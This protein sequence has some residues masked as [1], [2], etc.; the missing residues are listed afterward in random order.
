[1]TAGQLL[2]A[3]WAC[4]SAFFALLW[5]A[6]VRSRD[7]SLVDVGWALGLGFVGASAALVLDG[8]PARRALVG[9]MA[10]GWSLRLAAHLYF[11][12]VRGKPEDGRYAALRAS[13]GAGA[14]GKFFVFFQAQALLDVLLGLSFVAVA[15]RPGP[16]GALDAAGALLWLASVSGEAL[17]DRRLA[18]FRADPANKGQVCR[19]GLWSLSRH[20]NYF[21]EWTHWLAYGAM[22]PGDW[23]V[24]VAPPLMLYFL[25]RVTGIPA[26]E[27]QAL[28]GR[29]AAYRRYQDEVSMFVP[30]PPRRSS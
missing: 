26:T 23:R 14:D 6:Q 30:W 11:D 21:F 7:A 24:W 4:L 5:L 13:W 3:S 2:L 18:A 20:P 28:R 12:R 29:G 25:L 16:L 8:E 17:A 19:E 9:A 1:M 22:A 27:E 15:S 10:A